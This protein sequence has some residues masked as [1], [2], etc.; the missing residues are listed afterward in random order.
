[1]KIVLTEEQYKL[2]ER[3]IDEATV[4]FSKKIENGGYLE[5]IQMIGDTE[6]TNAIKISQVF[7]SG[8]FVEGSSKD[9]KFIINVGG[10]LNEDENT[11]TVM[12]DA[13]YKKGYKDAAGKLHPE[14][15]VGGTKM[16]IKNV[17]KV[18]VS[19]ASKNVVDEI[20]TKLG[21]EK[22]E[23]GE[24]GDEKDRE[25]FLK[26]SK[27]RSEEKKF[28]EKRVYD[29]VMS[30]PTLKKAIHQQTGLLDK[31]MGYGASVGVGPAQ[32]LIDK[33]MSKYT[34]KDDEKSGTG[35]DA[36]FGEFK[37]NKSVLFEIY[38]KPIRI[39]Y[40]DQ[41][42]SLLAGKNYK[43]R[44]VGKKYLTAKYDTNTHFKIYMKESLG[45]DIYKGTV[46]AFFKEDDGSI[47]DKMSDIM[48]QIKDYNY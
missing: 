38:G 25:E 40:G 33:Y 20:Y 29:L 34:G 46:K 42:L 43:A 41:N 35:K 26:R 27:E 13:E 37:V 9:G 45:K 5:I 22:M 44:Y 28:R 1:M 11:F 2:I 8:K 36:G 10:S 6:K 12:K 3:I 24:V 21:E 30:D 17:M 47:V 7:G 15:V 48:I 23:S 19:D 32:S 14:Q 4:P 31:L 16:T 39:S 18:T